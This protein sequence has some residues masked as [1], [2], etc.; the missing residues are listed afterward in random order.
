MWVQNDG[1]IRKSFV[2]PP[3]G[4]IP[5]NRITSIK[6]SQWVGIE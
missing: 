1:L 2:I 3:V 6:P 4:R 5:V